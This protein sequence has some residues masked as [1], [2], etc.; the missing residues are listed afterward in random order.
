MSF[1]TNSRNVI[2]NH[3]DNAGDALNRVR[4]EQ[5]QGHAAYTVQMPSGAY[6]V[7]VYL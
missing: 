2:V 5:S 6:E 3:F 4:F 1:H 7:R